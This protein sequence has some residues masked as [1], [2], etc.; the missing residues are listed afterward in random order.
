M[1]RT[2]KLKLALDSFQKSNLNSTLNN[3]NLKSP[4]RKIL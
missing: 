2:M 3:N 4:T 1:G